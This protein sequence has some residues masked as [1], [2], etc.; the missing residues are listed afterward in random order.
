MMGN[1]YPPSPKLKYNPKLR[2]LIKIIKRENTKDY[3]IINVVIMIMCLHPAW[4]VN[5][6]VLIGRTN[7][8]E[9]LRDEAY[10]N[11]Q[12]YRNRKYQ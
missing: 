1:R 7:I 11:S 2:K 8:Y 12:V 9:Y 5:N 6:Y 10:F 3:K 4:N